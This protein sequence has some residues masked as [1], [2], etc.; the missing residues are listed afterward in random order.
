MQVRGWEVRPRRPEVEARSN[1]DDS[2]GKLKVSGFIAAFDSSSLSVK[3]EGRAEPVT[4]L[5]P[6]GSDMLG[7]AVGDFVD[8]YCKYDGSHWLLKGLYSDHG[9]LAVDE[10]KAWFGLS[11]VI[12]EVNSARISVQVEHHP[13]YVT[14]A[15]PA[16][17]DTEGFAVGEAVKLY[18]KNVGDGFKVKALKSDHA[19]INEDGTA[20]FYLNGTIASLSSSEIGLTAEHHS[21]PVTCAVPAGADLSAFASGETAVM[22]C[23]FHDGH[24]VLAALKTE[25]ASIVL[26]P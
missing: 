21:S 10:G 18:C 13:G 11:G 3:V 12:V 19:A 9:A 17:M 14:C 25:H 4:C 15:V 7:F 6:A 26:E 1:P 5:L 20:W 22:K 2:T 23:R 24:F 16:G 8:M